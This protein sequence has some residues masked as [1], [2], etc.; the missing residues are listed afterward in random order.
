MEQDI[1][2]FHEMDGSCES[3]TVATVALRDNVQRTLHTLQV[4]MFRWLE[5]EQLM[6]IRRGNRM[7]EV[8]ETGLKVN[9]FRLGTPNQRLKI[10][11]RNKRTGTNQRTKHSGVYSVNMS[12]KTTDH[13]SSQTLFSTSPVPQLR[14]PLEL[15]RQSCYPGV[16]AGMS[17]SDT[18]A[19]SN[20]TDTP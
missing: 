17:W 15:W 3:I 10:M 4:I 18:S 2:D 9:S 1:Q 12:W 16:A 6:Q 13:I 11:M 20:V 7:L 5:G 14:K 8:K 19:T